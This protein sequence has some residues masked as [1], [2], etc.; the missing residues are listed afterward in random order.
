MSESTN[1]YNAWVTEAR[2]HL[3][4]SKR[5]MAN[6]RTLTEDTDRKSSLGQLI[7]DAGSMQRYLDS[8]YALKGGE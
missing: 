2:A 4:A 8:S 7:D 5:A 3:D 6:A 1:Q